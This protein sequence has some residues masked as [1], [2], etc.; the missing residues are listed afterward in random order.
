MK[1]RNG[2][3]SNSSTSSFVFSGYLISEGNK[4]ELIK[5][6]GLKFIP[7]HELDNEAERYYGGS[8]DTRSDDMQRA[9]IRDLLCSD[10]YICVLDDSENGLPDGYVVGLGMELYAGDAYEM[11]TLVFPYANLNKKLLEIYESIKEFESEDGPEFEP[12]IVT[13]IRMS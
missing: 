11:D 9:I 1:I 6:V 12:V 7:K 2:F 13:G 3:V 5:K 8:F 10:N 4:D